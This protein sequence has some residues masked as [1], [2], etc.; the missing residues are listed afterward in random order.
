MKVLDYCVFESFLF[1]LHGKEFFSKRFQSQAEVEYDNVPQKMH[2]SMCFFA[3]KIHE[4]LQPLFCVYFYPNLAAAYQ[5]HVVVTF[6]DS[7]WQV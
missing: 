1:Y 4:E 6:H 3:F 7:L 5:A 2:Q